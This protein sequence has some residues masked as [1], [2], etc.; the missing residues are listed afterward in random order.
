MMRGCANDVNALQAVAASIHR[1]H[2]G[3][4]SDSEWQNGR[5]AHLTWE[6]HPR[7]KNTRKPEGKP[8]YTT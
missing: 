6:W 8:A 2:L 5:G 7:D 1:C 4:S 3:A